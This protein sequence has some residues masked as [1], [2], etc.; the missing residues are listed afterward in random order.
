M[1]MKKRRASVLIV[2]GASQD[3]ADL[4]ETLLRDRAARYSVIE[5]DT[6]ASAIELCR[7]LSPDCLTLDQDLPDQ[8]GLDVLKQLAAENGSLD[9]AVV[10]LAGARA[11]S[12]GSRA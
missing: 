1:D 3:L 2:D 12:P 6:G 4:R 8:S 5:A 7:E 9:C 10:V 11:P